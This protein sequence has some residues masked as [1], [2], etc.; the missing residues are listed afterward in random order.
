MAAELTSTIKTSIYDDGSTQASVHFYKD[1]AHV[2]S[3]DLSAPSAEEFI[4]KASEHAPE[5]HVFVKPAE[6]TET[7]AAEESAPGAGV[8]QR[9]GDLPED[10]P[11]KLALA[12]AKI[13]TYEQVAT[14]DDL[15]T[16]P[17]IG[18]VTAEKI[19]EAMTAA[20]Y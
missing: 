7:A 9:S 12:E 3:K 15:T 19:D 17:G 5:G 6:E 18:D 16:I 13:T 4:D 10:F 1:G 11:G 20:G 8:T 14:V 2:G